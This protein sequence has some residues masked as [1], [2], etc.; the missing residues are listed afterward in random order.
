MHLI[1]FR[2][3]SYEFNIQNKQ[4]SKILPKSGMFKKLKYT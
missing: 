2:I 4:I 3:V 1:F